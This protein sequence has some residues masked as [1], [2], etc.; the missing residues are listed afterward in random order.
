DVHGFLCST[1][2]E[3]TLMEELGRG[4]ASPCPGVVVLDRATP[5]GETD[6]V[7]ARQV[8]PDASW[9]EGASIRALA[10]GALDALGGPLERRGVPF[11]L[12]VLTPDDPVDPHLP[13]ELAR[14]AALLRQT[15]RARLR[16]RRRRVARLEAPEAP[17]LVQILLCTRTRLLASA[18]VPEAL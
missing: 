18:S 11:R 16:E 13:G 8:L 9:V 1:G 4:A 3:A 14:R 12:D 2:F 15:F 5:L 6:A 17:S 10:D 7:F